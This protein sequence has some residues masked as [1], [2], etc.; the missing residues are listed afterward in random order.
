MPTP[1]A[2][3]PS[4]HVRHR[5]R[6]AA[7][8]GSAVAVAVVIAAVSVGYQWR[9]RNADTSSASQ[10][11]SVAS[12]SAT[13]SASITP[14]APVADSAPLAMSS[15]AEAAMSSPVQAAVSSATAVVT[16]QPCRA[17]NL[18]VAAEFGGAATGNLSQPFVLTNTGTESCVLQGYPIRLQGLHD[19]RWQQLNF[20]EGTFFIEEDASPSPVQLAPGAQAELIIGT[21]DACNGGDVGDSKLYSRLLATLQ[22]QTSIELNAPVNAF[23]ELDV[24]AF[25]AL[26]IPESSPPPP[27]PGPWD[28]LQLQMRAPATATAGTTLSYTVTLSNP[29]DTDVAFD[30]CPTWKALIDNPV[31]PD[32]ITQVSG[33]IDCATTPSVPAHGMITLQMHINVPA[34]AGTAK[35]VWWLTG[36]AIAVG[37]GLTIVPAR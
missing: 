16:S 7:A 37:E 1:D 31:G 4:S 17:S 24:S 34:E 3:S 26:P 21:A 35:F 2:W 22:N 11:S 13:P 28:A 33:P 32:A 15:P 12:T 6:N 5:R 8:L 9:T 18:N 19:G 29:K 23:C 36:D 10:L 14:S 30:P 20:T 27:T 25:H